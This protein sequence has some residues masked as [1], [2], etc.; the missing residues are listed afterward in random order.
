L[1]EGPGGYET[2]R[3]APLARVADFFAGRS[4]LQGIVARRILGRPAPTDPRL[5]RQL[6]SI[7]ESR[8]RPDG[9]VDGSLLATARAIEDLVALGETGP[10]LGRMLDWVAAQAGRPG[11]FGEGC[12]AAR[13]PH[14]LCEHFLGGFFAAAAPTQRAAPAT[15]PNGKVWR[16]ESQARFAASC[17]ALRATL[18]AGRTSDSAT[19]R[20]LDGF[21]YLLETWAAWD[22][23][24]APELA[25][26]ALSALA[27]APER[28]RKTTEALI[29]IVAAR[30]LPDGTWSK[31][32]FFHGLEGLVSVPSAAVAPLLDRAVPGL[33]SRQREDGSF[34]SVAPDERAL[35][36]LLVLGRGS[37]AAS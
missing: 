19:E 33:E 1:L 28:W 34:G 16:V 26:S 11:A 5:H 29:S 4:T 9:S 18:R 15:L 17:A 35:I 24:L 7:T 23:H 25:F 37:F 20:H 31:V 10:S 32:D 21:D 3:R 36:G 14:R 13:H 22:E 6:L 30:Q 2:T 12:T 8:I 27:F